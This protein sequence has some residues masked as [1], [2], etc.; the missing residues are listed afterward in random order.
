MI[1]VKAFAMMVVLAVGL[2]VIGLGS[3][4]GG[5]RTGARAAAFA[6]NPQPPSSVDPGDTG[7]GFSRSG[8]HLP[9][10]IRWSNWRP[11]FGPA[12]VYARESD[13]NG[14]LNLDA[15]VDKMI[16]VTSYDEVVR[17]MRFADELRAA[18]VTTIGFNTENGPGMTPADEM[19]TLNSADSDVNVVARVAQRA[20]EQG[21]KVL[22]GPVRRM[23]DSVSDQAVLAI[24]DA[25]VTGLAIQEQ[26]FIETQ[27]ADSR[28]AAVNRTRD[29]YLRLAQQAGLDDFT[30]HVQIMQ[31]RCPNLDNCVG[32]VEGLEEIPVDS[33]AIWS[34]G[35]IPTDF[36]YAIRM[37]QGN[38]GI[39]PNQ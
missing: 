20:I 38:G 23:T 19:Q 17:L 12:I 26:K 24:M 4:S 25:G 2:V 27:P 11:E 16:M 22:W 15:P 30:F 14:M 6:P 28:L 3:L 21:F 10:M 8:E 5:N 29:R 36:V 32:F 33:I 34:N 35:P 7:S 9:L 1:N 37:Q 13:L 39:I 18:G 31:Q